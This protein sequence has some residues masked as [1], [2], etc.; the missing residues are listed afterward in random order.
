MHP[1]EAIRAVD[2][3]ELLGKTVVL[4]VCG[5]IA[6]V[7]VVKLARELIR[8][9]ATVHAV[10]SEAAR[11]LI[12]PNALQFATGR[13]AIESL[14]GSVQH[15]DLCG[16]RGEADC[17][18]VAPA[19]AN[20]I[21]K[22]ALGI[23]DTPVTTFATTAL[24]ARLPLLVAPAMD[25]AMYDHP[26]IRE[27][28]ETLRSGGV[29][30]IEPVLAEEKAKLADV[31]VITAHV[32]RALGPQDLKGKRVLVIAGA[33]EE[34]LDDVRVVSNRSTGET[35]VE[36]ARA[37]YLRGG[38]VDLWMGRAEVPLPAYLPLH[39]FSDLEGLLSKLPEV[40]HDFCAVPAALAD[41]VPERQAG[42][43]PSS[44]APLSVSFA[45][46]PRIL[47]TLR[48]TYRGTLIG[49]KLEA[50]VESKTLRTQAAERLKALKLD[51]VVA[52]DAADVRPGSTAVIL[53][54]RE[55]REEAFKGT[56]R[57]VSQSLWSAILHGLKR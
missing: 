25:G 55:G 33:T 52:N 41:F 3:E 39:R 26:R 12:H 30:V 47:E 20:T 6:A 14:D 27:H 31:A 44:K 17:L 8:H 13:P 51:F 49:F 37:A 23:D 21:A 35:G 29:D 56:K 19:T 36:L 11:G 45:P 16:P 48:K 15:V 40:D 7:E 18:L 53:L 34:P 5:S 38:Q 10:M 43:I 2:G 1:S 42:K 46:A 9:G 50:G 22:I 24:G 32:M 4:A 57:D 28:L 54:D